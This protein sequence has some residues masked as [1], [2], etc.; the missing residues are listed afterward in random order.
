[1]AVLKLA[2]MIV[3]ATWA[4][5]LVAFTISYRWSAKDAAATGSRQ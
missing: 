1:M 2:G 5:E 4:F 3:A